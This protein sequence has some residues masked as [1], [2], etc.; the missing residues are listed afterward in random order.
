MI[1]LMN[2]LSQSPRSHRHLLW[3][4]RSSCDVSFLP[5][6]LF[7]SPSPAPS[8]CPAPGPSLSPGSVPSPC[9]G[10]PWR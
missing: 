5:P 7:L 6:C 3:A 8:L 1:W 9:P 2:Y 10:W 4:S